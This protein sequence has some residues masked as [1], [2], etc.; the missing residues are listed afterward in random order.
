MDN[1]VNNKKFS[2]IILISSE[3]IR[4]NAH[5]I[6]LSRISY[7][8]NLFNCDLKES[9]DK[10][11]ICDNVN[12]KVLMK[13]MKYIY[14]NYCTIEFDDAINVH[15]AANYF[16]LDDLKKICEDKILMHINKDVVCEILIVGE[17]KY[18]FFFFFII[19]SFFFPYL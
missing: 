19:F 15:E 4:V 18:Y 14:T 5:K 11:I 6:I 13:I 1:F 16:G 3:G 2:D 10:E 7:F 12:H 9:H 8:E 17:K